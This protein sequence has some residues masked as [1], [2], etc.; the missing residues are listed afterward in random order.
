MQKRISWFLTSLCTLSLSVSALESERLQLAG[1]VPAG[2]LVDEPIV[3]IETSEIN[4]FG[5]R[6]LDLSRGDQRSKDFYLY[7]RTRGNLNHS[8]DIILITPQGE[9]YRQ[10]AGDQQ[11]VFKLDQSNLDQKNAKQSIKVSIVAH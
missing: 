8:A 9:S 3:R 11:L 6:E 5:A 2:L 10:I 4:D 7:F 1:R